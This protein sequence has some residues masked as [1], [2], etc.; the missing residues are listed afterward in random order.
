ML[1]T[2]IIL[3]LH[4]VVVFRTIRGHPFNSFHWPFDGQTTNSLLIDYNS[5][6]FRFKGLFDEFDA[7]NRIG[8]EKKRAAFQYRIVSFELS[9]F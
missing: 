5:Y 7:D 1:K 2:P 4:V 9:P 6:G 3:W 8:S